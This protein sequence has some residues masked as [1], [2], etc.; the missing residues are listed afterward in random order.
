[1]AEILSA[2]A[3]KIAAAP[4]QKLDTNESHGRERIM[5]AAMPVTY[6][7]ANV[8]D[9]VVLGRIPQ[10]SRILPT[11]TLGCGAGTAS[12]TLDIGIRRASTKEVIDADGI[13]V[14]VNIAA[15]GTNKPLNTGALLANGASYVTPWEV[16]VYATVG[17]AALAANQVLS[18]VLEYVTD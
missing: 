13:A 9:T 15:A 1:M 4:L 6:P 2:Q 7:G 8:A 14:G 17:G 12:S 5:F 18:L 11:G 10:G 3:A 16:E